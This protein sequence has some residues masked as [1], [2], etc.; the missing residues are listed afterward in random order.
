MALFLQSVCYYTKFQLKHKANKSD[1]F[2]APGFSSSDRSEPLWQTE[3]HFTDQ[4]RARN[5]LFPN[6]FY[7]SSNAI[8]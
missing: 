6:N 8:S 1:T 7:I 4:F 2:I 5:V 3:N